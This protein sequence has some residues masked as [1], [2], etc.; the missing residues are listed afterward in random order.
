MKIALAVALCFSSLAYADES[1]RGYIRKDGTYVAPHMRSSPNSTRIDNYGSQG[2]F[3]PYTGERGTINPYTPPQPT[4]SPPVNIY[5][6]PTYN[7][8]PYRNPYGTR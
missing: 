8:Q 1:V 2:N 5:Q 7:P 3:N 4:Y 6:P